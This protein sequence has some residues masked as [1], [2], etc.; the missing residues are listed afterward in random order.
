MP[1]RWKLATEN[2]HDEAFLLHTHRHV[3]P[4]LSRSFGDNGPACCSAFEGYRP[5]HAPPSWTNASFTRSTSLQMPNGPQWMTKGK[6]TDNNVFHSHIEHPP[7]F[8]TPPPSARGPARSRFT[9]ALCVVSG[10]TFVQLVC[11][12]GGAMA[13]SSARDRHWSA[14]SYP[15][16]LMGLTHPSRGLRSPDHTED[17]AMD[18][19]GRRSSPAVGRP[20]RQGM[21]R[22]AGAADG[23]AGRSGLAGEAAEAAPVAQTGR[24]AAAVAPRGARQRR[25]SPPPPRGSAS[26]PRAQAWPGAR[27]R[28]LASTPMPAMGAAPLSSRRPRRDVARPVSYE[29]P[30]LSIKMRK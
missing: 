26:S 18:A 30:S 11:S 29:E 9:R 25:L 20:E 27:S 5:R 1:L 22:P 19:T 15:P 3:M 8:L 10:N 4:P 6:L 13:A 21:A 14:P 12:S 16:E 2:V 7:L 24:D 28:P 17:D 23:S